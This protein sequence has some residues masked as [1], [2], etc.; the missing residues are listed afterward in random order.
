MSDAGSNLAAVLHAP[1]DLRVEEYA[2]PKP[3]K[4]EV[5]L[6]IRKVG[7]CGSDVE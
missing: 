4:G 5:L 1:N 6:S 7:I 2:M 3:G